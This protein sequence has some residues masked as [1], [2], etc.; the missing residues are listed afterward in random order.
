[1]QLWRT[2]EDRT[3]VVL[4]QRIV[5]TGSVRNENDEVTGLP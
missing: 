1:M 5:H 3:E 2:R 4:P